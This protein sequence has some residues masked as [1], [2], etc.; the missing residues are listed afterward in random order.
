MMVI[1]NGTE[2]CPCLLLKNTLGLNTKK[3]SAAGRISAL[4]E[5]KH[6]RKQK[7]SLSLCM[8]F[9]FPEGFRKPF[10]YSFGMLEAFYSMSKI[11]CSRVK[12]SLTQL[13]EAQ[14]NG[15]NAVLYF[16]PLSTV[17]P[18]NNRLPAYVRRQHNL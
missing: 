8:L 14:P 18:W 9:I 10:Y 4:R 7:W 11:K 3:A 15:C 17:A 2:D 6:L 1:G 5:I 16:S 12:Q 13:T